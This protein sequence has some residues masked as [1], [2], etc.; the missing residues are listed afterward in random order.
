MYRNIFF[1]I[2]RFPKEAR[3]CAW[4]T[5]QF[6]VRYLVT[7]F[8]FVP[9]QLW[10]QCSARAVNYCPLACLDNNNPRTH[11]PSSH[12]APVARLALRFHSI[13]G[14]LLT[15][16]GPSLRPRRTF[17]PLSPNPTQHAASGSLGP[18]NSGAAQIV[19]DRSPR[20]HNPFTHPSSSHHL[21]DLTL[22]LTRAP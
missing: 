10:H 6:H 13:P 16:L 1:G 4:Q 18:R 8:T 21:I 9:L 15:S 5:W 19:N 12:A 7:C 22:T 20:I 2:M 11:P 3:P 14:E 17:V